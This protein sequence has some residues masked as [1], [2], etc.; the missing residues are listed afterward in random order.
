LLAFRRSLIVAH[1]FAHG[2]PREE[3]DQEEHAHDRNVVRFGHDK[4]KVGIRK[5]HGEEAEHAGEE[6]LGRLVAVER[7]RPLERGKQEDRS[8]CDQ[9]PRVADEVDDV[10]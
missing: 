6:D 7:L 9:D 10:F 2:K 3:G 4:T 8:E 5:T 1:R